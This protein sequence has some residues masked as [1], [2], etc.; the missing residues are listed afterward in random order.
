[1]TIVT[2]DMLAY[3]ERLKESGFTDQQATGQAK[4]Q[5]EMF[6]KVIEDKLATKEDLKDAKFEII[7]WVGGITVGSI[8]I[9]GTVLGLLSMVTK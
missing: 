1:M 5:A 4:A 3:A 7:K 6:L 2:L 8:S 9:V